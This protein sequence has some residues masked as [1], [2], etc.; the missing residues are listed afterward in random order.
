MSQEKPTI[1]HVGSR[2]TLRQLRDDIFRLHGFAV[3]STLS[4]NQVLADVPKQSYDLVLIDVEGERRVEEAERL[5]AEIKKVV[6]TQHV[7]YVCNYRVAI[8]SE[9][10]DDI[11]RNEFDPEALIRS[12]KEVI[13]SH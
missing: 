10:P 8:H 9:C 5:C 11:I 4:F 13:S 6:P 12:L 1:Y 3:A 7:A 2:E